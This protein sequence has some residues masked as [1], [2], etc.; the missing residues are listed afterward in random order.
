M[1][2]KTTQ[3]ITHSIVNADNNWRIKD[4][5]FSPQTFSI[6][7]L[8]KLLFLSFLPCHSGPVFPTKI[9]MSVCIITR[10]EEMENKRPREKELFGI[11]CVITGSN[12]LFSSSDGHFEVEAKTCQDDGCFTNL[13]KRSFWKEVTYSSVGESLEEIKSWR[14]RI[15][16][17][18]R[19]FQNYSD[20][21]FMSR[22]L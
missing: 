1:V 18:Q 16:S 8:T 13:P 3:A 6:L 7:I 2:Y 20:C 21:T 9:I 15:S 11:P 5:C 14:N 22:K 10:K 17:L 4:F 19:T 12:E